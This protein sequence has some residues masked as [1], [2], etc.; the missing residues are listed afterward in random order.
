MA[1]ILD[2]NHTPEHEGVWSGRLAF[3]CQSG[4][5]FPAF[6]EQSIFD[7]AGETRTRTVVMCLAEGE[8]RGEYQPHDLWFWA[9]FENLPLGLCLIDVEGLIVEGNKAFFCLCEGDRATLKDAALATFLSGDG[10]DIWTAAF[11]RVVLDGSQTAMPQAEVYFREKPDNAASFGIIPLGGAM[12]MAHFSD[13]T[14]RRNLE[15]QFEQAQK[16]Q[17]MGQ[18]AGGVAHDFNNLLTAMIGFCDLLLQRHN[19][20]DPSFADLMQI[21][22]NANRA[23]NLVRQLLAFSRKQPLQACTLRVTDALTEISHLL[24]RLLGERIHLDLRLGRDVGCIRVDPGQFDQVI[25]NL[26]V[27]ARDAMP[28]GGH[29]T[30][31]T[32]LKVLDAPMEIGAESLPAG[33]YVVI[34]VHDTGSGI[35]RED[36]A[37]ILSPFFR[38]KQALPVQEPVLAF[39]L[40][41]ASF[42][43]QAEGFSPSPLSVKERRL[44]FTCRM[45]KKSHVLVKASCF[46]TLMIRLPKKTIESLIP[47]AEPQFYWW[48]TRMRF[49]FLQHVLFVIRVT[50]SSKPPAASRPWNS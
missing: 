43:K 19:V 16:M 40:F 18:L 5:T 12:F 20:G 30:L 34:T 47:L 26:A 8:A 36:I 2:G 50:E 31:T 6:V 14:A 38:R 33:D 37:R 45:M 42:A 35:A 21:K 22:Q 4:D 27:N 48:K 15:I 24:R 11:D 46:F 29:L 28:E 25:I 17:A 49:D 1:H 23:A 7:N 44:L 41:T 13:T 32:H 3:R 10:R 39:R 9:L